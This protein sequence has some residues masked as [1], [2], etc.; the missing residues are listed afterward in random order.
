VAI[1]ASILKDEKFDPAIPGLEDL[2]LW[3]RISLRFPV[4]QIKERTI[5]YNSHIES[6]TIGDTKRYEKELKYF[7][8]IFDKKIYSRQLP[9]KS[10]KRLLS[11]CHFHLAVKA[12][13]ENQ[14]S[15]TYIHA[16]KSFVLYPK[17]Y[18]GKTNKILFVMCLYSLPLL[19]NVFKS[20]ITYCK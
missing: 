1:A 2:E 6:Y 20:L 13:N 14:K 8:Y 5:I 7:K 15:K 11:M 17:G 9:I 16:V 12:N 19:G 18:N 4:Y 10:K 3:L